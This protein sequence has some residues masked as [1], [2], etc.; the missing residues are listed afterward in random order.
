MVDA[1]E[2]AERHGRS[3]SL[4]KLPFE[5]DRLIGIRGSLQERF[6]F[7]AFRLSVGLLTHI[8]RKL[9]EPGFE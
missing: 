7:T 5:V 4:T 9:V 3:T 6:A 2:R 1:C 8:L